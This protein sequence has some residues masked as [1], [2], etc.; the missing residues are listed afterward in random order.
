M[1]VLPTMI[2]K[3][4]LRAYL[5]NPGPP[6]SHKTLKRRL[7]RDRI[8]ERAKMVWEDIATEQYLPPQITIEI[9]Q[10]YRIEAL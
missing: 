10:V 1:N 6:I 3:K 2:T 5:G 9:Y 4:E 7:I 8:L